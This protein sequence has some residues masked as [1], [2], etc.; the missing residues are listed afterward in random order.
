MA[1]HNPKPHLKEHQMKPEKGLGSSD[2]T[3]IT[4]RLPHEDKAQLQAIAKEKETKPGE[5]GREVIQAYIQANSA[6]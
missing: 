3:T 5:L 1:N 2:T 4:I 6:K